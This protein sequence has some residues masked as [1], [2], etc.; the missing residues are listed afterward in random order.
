MENRTAESE[1]TWVGF[2]VGVNTLTSTPTPARSRSRL[3]SSAGVEAD[4]IL[5]TLSLA[6]TPAKITDSAWLRLRL[7]LRSPGL[8]VFLIYQYFVDKHIQTLLINRHKPIHPTSI[9]LVPYSPTFPGSSPTSSACQCTDN[10]QDSVGVSYAPHAMWW[11]AFLFYN[12]TNPS[13][14]TINL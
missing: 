14:R 2:V 1:S 10:T 11:K 8:N 3:K 6:S 12:V 7:G 5:P 9:S 13:N 4:I